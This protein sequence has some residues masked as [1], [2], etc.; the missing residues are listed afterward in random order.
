MQGQSASVHDGPFNSL[1]LP[2]TDRRPLLTQFNEL[3]GAR[4]YTRRLTVEQAA[5]R[6]CACEQFYNEA[7]DM[8]LGVLDMELPNGVKRDADGFIASSDIV[9]HVDCFRAA[10][11]RL[12]AEEV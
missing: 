7:N 4:R 11:A 3:W 12:D 6:R 10:L 9:K 5:V 1:P 8:L 2:G